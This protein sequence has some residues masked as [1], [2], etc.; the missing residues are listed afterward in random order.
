MQREATPVVV[1]AASETLPQGKLMISCM[2]SSAWIYHV[3]IPML[4]TGGSMDAAR[5][6]ATRITVV[7]EAYQNCSFYLS[8]FEGVSVDSLGRSIFVRLDP[9]RC[10]QFVAC[11]L[12]CLR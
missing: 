9:S 2:Y 7:P 1:T 5:N 11:C 3:C 4:A 12:G 10:E 8:S 6:E